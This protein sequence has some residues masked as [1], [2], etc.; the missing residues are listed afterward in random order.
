MAGGS[1]LDN[2][3]TEAIEVPG[4]FQ[5]TGRKTLIGNAPDASLF[6][7]F[8]RHGGRRGP[9]SFTTL[10]L[11]K[12]TSGLSVIPEAARGLAG[13]PTGALYFDRCF[14]PTAAVLGRPGG[15]FGVFSTAMLWERSCLL[16]GF[17]GS[18]ER[19]LRI[20]ID[21]LANKRDAGG[22]LLR[23]Q[24]ISHRLA[25]MRLSL[26]GA[27]LMLY[28]AAWTIDQGRNNYAIAAMAK[29]A[30]SEAVVDAAQDTFRLLA[31]AGWRGEVGNPVTGV[32]D[33]LAGLLASGTSDIQLE[34]I[35]RQMYG[36]PHR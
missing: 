27:R 15:G 36:E 24:A 2:I 21:F 22:S 8:A 16:A 34:L 29:L 3:E 7:V 10:M 35:A 11:A 6:I 32:A 9:M 19:D 28:R 13:A 1:S 20:C 5:V 18:A 12:G 17:L 26:D 33:A 23:H 14:V 4:G 31:G 30:V 25:R